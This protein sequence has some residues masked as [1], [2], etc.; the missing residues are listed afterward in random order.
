MSNYRENFKRKE[1]KYKVND[2]QRESIVRGIISHGL[3]LTKFGESRVCS[4]YFDTKSKDVISRSLEKPLYKEKIRLR[5]YGDEGIENASNVFI[6]LKK[7]FK[8][9]VYKR[10]VA[11]TTDSAINFLESSDISMLVIEPKALHCPSYIEEQVMKEI[12]FAYNRFD[13]MT[14]ATRI[15][16]F[17]SPYE[18]TDDFG[19]RITFDRELIGLDLKSGIHRELIEKDQSIMEIKCNGAYPLWLVSILNEAKAYPHSF[20]KYGELYM[21]QQGENIC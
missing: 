9:I 16:Y 10:R 20:S 11:V 15:S 17:R 1:V 14:P 18:E 21:M 6:E 7:K 3:S 13:G 4:I 2:M 12:T 5:W 19:L 8:G